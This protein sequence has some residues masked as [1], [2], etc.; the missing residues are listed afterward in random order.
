MQISPI[1][2]ALYQKLERAKKLKLAIAEEE[3]KIEV[4]EITSKVTFFY[5]KLRNSVDFKEVH[6]LRR[7]AIERN[8]R[9][10]LLLETL[11][12]QIAKGLIEDLIR[13]RYLPNNALPEKFILQV[14]HIIKRYNDLFLLLNDLYH[15][16]ERKKYFDWLVGIEAC[17][18]DMLLSPETIGDSV[19]E[20]MYQAIKPRIKFSGASVDE[21]R[22]REKNVQLYIA[23]HKSLVKSDDTIIAYH[24]FNLYF[25]DWRQADENLVK[26]VAA[27]FASIHR[28]LQHHLKHPYQKKLLNTIKEDV[29]TFKIL[30]ELILLKG[31]DL[32]DLLADPEQ[33]LAEAKI[34]INQKYKI[35]GNKIRQSSIRAVI[36][37]FV[38]KMTLALIFELPYEVYI[39]KE[40]HYL[41]L[42]INVLL[43]PLLMF[44]ITLTIVPPTK[45][46][47]NKIL[48]NLHNII[49][50]E[51]KQ[52]ILC[53]LNVKYSQNWGFRTF[54]YSMFTTLY[55][56]VFGFIIMLLQSLSFNILS[57]TLFLFFLTMVSFFALKIR[58]TAKEYKVLQKKMGLLAFL[59]DF[60]SLPI[61]SAGRWLST[62]FKKINVF[63]FVMDYIIE[64]PFKIFIATFEDWLGFLKDKKEGM[65]HDE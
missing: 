56:L 20:T 65:Y 10:R 14:A 27:N 23:I 40:L 43:P 45:E 60:F 61:V 24:S 1:I 34:L 13:S 36:Y 39:V 32:A 29:V 37:I 2:V 26:V 44:L 64:A 4:E 52:S 25:P 21:V 12:P 35:V 46:N 22:V 50:G 6:L 18:I 8:L 19:I 33:F 38:T 62:K 16:A 5:E 57:G 58:S 51:P 48:D 49:Y 7:F 17:E 9:R 54:Y 55:I 42:I 53:K 63:A 31:D 28:T 47:T 30:Y 41:P 11:K 15:T 59:I 3:N